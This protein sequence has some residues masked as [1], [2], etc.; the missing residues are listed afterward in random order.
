MYRSNKLADPIAAHMASN[1]A[2]V[3]WSISTEQWALL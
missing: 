2:I 1:A 3:V